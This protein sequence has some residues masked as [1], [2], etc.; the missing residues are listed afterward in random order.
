MPAPAHKG[1]HGSK[2]MIRITDTIN[3]LL[4]VPQ[5]PANQRLEFKT[6]EISPVP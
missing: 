4:I 3:S 6:G 1:G 5:L 2:R